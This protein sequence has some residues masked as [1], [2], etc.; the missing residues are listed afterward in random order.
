[1][2]SGTGTCTVSYN[3]AGDS[4]FSAAAQVTN[5]TNPQKATQTINVTQSAPGTAT[6]NSTFN[7]AAT[8]GASGQP[9]LIAASGACSAG[10][11]G[12]AT[13]TMTTGT[14]ACTVTYNQV[15]T[16]TTARWPR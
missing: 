10:G 14:G 6:Y 2:D 16:P 9:V 1:M 12:S 3:Q 8:G 7:V 4:N 15:V 11:S 5:T 13:M